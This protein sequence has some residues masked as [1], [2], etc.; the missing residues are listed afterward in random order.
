MVGMLDVTIFG[1][2][3]VSQNFTE[4]QMSRIL[5]SKAPATFTRFVLFEIGGILVIVKQVCQAPCK[6][7]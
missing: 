2:R 1:K 7:L 3:L 5:P 4:A 6:V